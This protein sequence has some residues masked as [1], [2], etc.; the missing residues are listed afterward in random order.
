MQLTETYVRHA[1]ERI[2]DFGRKFEYLLNTGNLASRSGLDLSQ[3]TG[4]TVIAEKLNFHRYLAHFRAVHRGAY[5]MEIR[6]TTVRK[7]RPEAFGFMCPVHTPD[8]APCGLLNHFASTCNVVAHAVRP[9]D[10]EVLRNLII[11]YG[12]VPV[13]LKAPLRM[14]QYLPVQIDG[15][16]A[17]YV[18]SSRVPALVQHLRELKAA[19]LESSNAGLAGNISRQ[20]A[21][22]FH[23]EVRCSPAAISD[24]DIAH[25]TILFQFFTRTM[26]ISVDVLKLP[27]VVLRHSGIFLGATRCVVLISK[28]YKAADL[29][30]SI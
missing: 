25:S 13:E 16:L 5:F 4:F 29:P 17:G 23:L 18:A 11:S 19:E 22:P 30:Y 9:E 24:S 12:V 21:I 28:M 1:A 6:T 7:L 26:S 14:P 10:V 20:P 8:G 15:E 3:S 2:S 27:W